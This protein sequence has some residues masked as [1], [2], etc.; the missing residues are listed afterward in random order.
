[1][2][3]S[4]ELS[5]GS[6]QGRQALYI[7]GRRLVVFCHGSIFLFVDTQDWQLVVVALDATP[8]SAL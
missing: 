7:D 5:G 6:R 3:K 2:G 4:C 1:M 8:C